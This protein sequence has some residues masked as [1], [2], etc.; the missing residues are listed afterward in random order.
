MGLGDHIICNGLVREL[1]VHEDRFFIFSKKHNAASV[2]HLYSDK[3]NVDII[4]VSGDAEVN[5]FLKKID[6]NSIIKI[7]Y[8]APNYDRKLDLDWEKYVEQDQRYFR[9]EEL[10]D[11]KGDSS[12]L[13]KTLRWTPEYTFESMLD[14]MVEYCQ[15]KDIIP[16]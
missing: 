16:T 2:R 14:E 13:R 9:P 5:R 15:N 12:K 10:T 6:A 7:G 11:L 3:E 8:F 4:S 1:L